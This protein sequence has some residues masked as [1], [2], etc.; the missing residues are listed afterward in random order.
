V[1]LQLRLCRCQWRSDRRTHQ[2]IAHTCLWL[3]T[4]GWGL[5]TIADV[6][7]LDTMRRHDTAG[8]DSIVLQVY[9]RG[10]EEADGFQ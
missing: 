1:A 2:F 3:L 4:T 10:L 9:N 6:D 7:V 8:L 5:E